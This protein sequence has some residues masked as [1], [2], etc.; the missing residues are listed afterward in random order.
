MLSALSREKN[1]QKLVIKTK[2]EIFRLAAGVTIFN[3]TE[4]VVLSRGRLQPNFNQKGG[5]KQ[6]ARRYYCRSSNAENDS[7]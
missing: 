3:P 1:D 7:G 5:G 2:S 4:K 6:S